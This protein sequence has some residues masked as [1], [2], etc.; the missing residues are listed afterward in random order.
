MSSPF[1][2]PLR[3]PGSKAR[4]IEFFAE[5]TRR[6][7]LV[8]REI[9]EPYAGS[10]AVSFGLLERELVSRAMFFER[11]PL[12]FSF[13]HCVFH[14]CEE[15]VEAVL[16][17]EVTLDTWHRLDE[18][19]EVEDVSEE[20]IVQLG[21][22]G[23]FFNRTNFSGVIHAGPIGGQSQSSDYSISCRFNKLDLV[24]RIREASSFSDRVSVFFGDALQ[25]LEDAKNVDNTN[26]FFY[27]DPPYFEQGRKLYRYHYRFGDHERLAGALADTPY[28][29]VL[30]YDSHAVIDFLYMNHHKFRHVFRYSSKGHKME[31]E[32]V[33]SNRRLDFAQALVAEQQAFPFDDEDEAGIATTDVDLVAE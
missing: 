12:V 18:L 32:L 16:S 22:A 15:L 19:R 14:R 27:I 25:A 24:K 26:R 5:I 6:N 33:I 20:N 17:V 28:D 30:S 3:Y 1:L 21:L 4:S 8:G 29:W 7:G 13:W 10:G 31:E 9:V 11:D 2:N 23:L